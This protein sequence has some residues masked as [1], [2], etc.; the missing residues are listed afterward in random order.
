[1]FRI[2]ITLFFALLAPS[3]LFAAAI[4]EEEQNRRPAP[5]YYSEYGAV[6]DGVTD[7]FQAIIDAH[8]AANITG[9]KVIADP[10]AVYYIGG[11]VKTAVI[12]TDT[13]WSGAQF[14]IDDS[15]VERSPNNRNVWLQSWVFHV[16]SALPSTEITT[17]Q[18][19]EKNQKKLDISL[20]YNSVLVAVNTA[21]KHYIRLGANQNSGAN[22]TDVFVVDRNGNVDI[23]TP[24]I[25][26]FNRISSI[27]AYPI[28]RT[29]LTIKGGRFTTIA[30]RGTGSEDYMGRGIRITRSNTLIDGLYH[31]VTEEGSSGAPYNGF[32]RVERNTN[33]TIQN[34]TLTGHRVYRNPSNNAQ[35]GTYDISASF[36]NNLKVLNCDQTNDINNSQW[37]GVFESDYSKNILFDKVK[38]SRFDAHRGVYNVTILNS[39]LGW[40]RI[41]IIGSGTLTVENTKVNSVYFIYLREDYGSTW[42]GDIIIRNCIFSPTAS[43]LNNAELIYARNDGRWN[44]GY[45]CYMPRTITIDGLTVED[46]NAQSSYQGILLFGNFNSSHT[47]SEPFPYITTREVNITNFSSRRDYRIT[48]DYLRNNLLIHNY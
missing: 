5:I 16:A 22:Q 46:A 13:D 1:M 41:S 40:Q 14:I 9:A 43:Q 25:W 35:L 15:A 45:Q 39:E 28:D 34:S 17:I 42:E 32:I 47:G 11:A 38:F 4:R 19:L 6:G 2:C 10:G 21:T 36:T 37:W 30:N 18:S 26:D 3:V 7:D 8:E 24:I 29:R 27:T 23:N 44:F 31:I 20:P 12:K 33:V 48:N